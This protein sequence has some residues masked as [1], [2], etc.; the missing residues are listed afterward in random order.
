[1]D[2]EGLWNGVFGRV[3]LSSGVVARLLRTVLCWNP[4]EK[5]RCI[6]K[7]RSTSLK[8][9][10]KD[11][12][13]CNKKQTA[14]LRIAL[15]YVLLSCSQNFLTLLCSYLY[16]STFQRRTD[17]R[18]ADWPLS[19]LFFPAGFRPPEDVGQVNTYPVQ[20]LASSHLLHV[21]HNKTCISR[22]HCFQSVP[23]LQSV[24]IAHRGRVRKWNQN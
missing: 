2:A 23:S 14:L 5:I 18:P 10:Y 11:K 7:K 13:K 3:T 19:V 20:R 6:N 22:S 15:Y 16:Y 21:Q 12:L 8:N 24:P 9:N 1:M 4:T 17:W